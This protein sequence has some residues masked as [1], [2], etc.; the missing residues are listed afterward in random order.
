MTNEMSQTQC[1]SRERKEAFLIFAVCVARKNSAN[2]QA[3]VIG[4]E[5][6]RQRRGCHT[7]AQRRR[8]RCHHHGQQGMEGHRRDPP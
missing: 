5:R 6:Y 2:T 8:G 7:D 3:A 4:I 1:W